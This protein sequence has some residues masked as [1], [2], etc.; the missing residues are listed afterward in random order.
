[1]RWWP[2]T[3]RWKMLL[4][5]V[6]LEALSISLFALLLVRLQGRDLRD[7]AKQRLI[8]QVSSVASQAQE[9][10]LENREDWLAASVR[11]MGKAPSVAQAKVTDPNGNM[12]DV[13]PGLATRT[14]LDP[15]ERGQMPLIR[16]TAPRVFTF[17]KIVGKAWS[18]FTSAPSFVAMH[19]SRAIESGTVS[20][21]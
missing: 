13:S 16:G 2:R 17:G 10:M 11:M 20:K 18:R 8:S 4:G 1:M 15:A 21:S 19:G 7:H 5:L 3:I 6:L 12:L 9:A 14:M